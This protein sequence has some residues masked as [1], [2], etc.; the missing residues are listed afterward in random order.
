[1]AYDLIVV[2]GGKEL[3]LVNTPP[4]TLQIIDVTKQ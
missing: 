4:G 1:M 2:S 3:F